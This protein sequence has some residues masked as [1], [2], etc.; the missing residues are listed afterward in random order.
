MGLAIDRLYSGIL[1][2]LP[3]GGG[4]PPTLVNATWIEFGDSIAAHGNYNVGTGSATQT[5]AVTT[6]RITASLSNSALFG[7]PRVAIVNMTDTTF[8]VIGRNFYN[9]SGATTTGISIHTTSGDGATGVPAGAS[10]VAA[11]TTQSLSTGTI[12][13]FERFSHRGHYTNINALL[14]GGIDLLANLG[15]PAA[16]A[17]QML[18]ELA[19]AKS[20]SPQVVRLQAG[21]NDAKGGITPNAIFANV[22][23]L[24]DGLTGLDGNG[25]TAFVI[26]CAIMP[27]GHVNTGYATTNPQIIGF[28]TDSALYS[29][30]T[31]GLGTVYTNSNCA[32]YQLAQYCAANPT[33]MIFID[34]FTDSYDSV[35][36]SFYDSVFPAPSGAAMT[37][38]G[39]H[40]L[41]NSILL[42]S[43][44]IYNGINSFISCDKIT[45]A[46]SSDAT[47]PNGHTRFKNIGPWVTT[48]VTTGFFTNGSVST[49]LPKGG[50]AGQPSGWACGQNGATAGT[51]KLSVYDP[52]DGKGCFVNGECT[53]TSANAVLC[54]FPLG[55]SGYAINGTVNSDGVSNVNGVEI[56][57]VFEVRWDGAVAAGLGLVRAALSTNTSGIYGFATS[58]ELTEIDV[59]NVLP[60][61]MSGRILRTGWC[62]MNN[63]SITALLPQIFVHLTSVTGVTCNV[64]V[65]AVGFIKK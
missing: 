33:K 63:A 25:G 23:V 19:Y 41:T 43:T 11:T 18:A 65:R 56:A 24:V 45:P 62:I 42:Q 39:T 49:L 50:V 32:N 14:G 30:T 4:S 52:G 16:T 9:D 38:D 27:L 57:F 60:D 13:D 35:N 6:G 17:A 40:P 47:T 21:T 53:A 55:N 29:G 5:R 22:K 26:V 37:G 64:S 48:T 44:R 61:T 59:V 12:I 58:G 46:S 51:M 2:K 3:S 31:Q 34:C 8:E 10:T 20:L 15:H 7:C 28:P 54:F 36:K 1:G